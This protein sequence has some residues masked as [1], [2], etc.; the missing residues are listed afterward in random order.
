MIKRVFRPFWSYDIMATEQWLADM[1]SSGLLLQSVNFRQRIFA[2]VVTQPRSIVYRID[3][4]KQQQGIS[5][6]LTNNGWTT[7]DVGRRW[8]IYANQD[9]EVFLFP[10]RD[11]VV[12]KVRS[13]SKLSLIL[14]MFVGFYLLITVGFITFALWGSSETTYVPA[15]YRI[16]DY[17][18]YL[19]MVVNLSFLAWIIYTFSKTK[20]S[21]QKFSAI[22]GYNVDPTLLNI[23]NQRIKK[24]DNL[25]K[26]I[27]VRKMFWIYK[28]DH[29]AEWLETQATRGL[30]LKH[31]HKNN[32][33]FEEG[34]PR[35]T[36]YFF[37]TQQNISEG[38]FDIH[39]QA[40]FDLL[41]DSRLQFGRLIL[42][43]KGY[44]ETQQVP[45]MYT[46][47]VEYLACAKRLLI[48][49]I[50][51]IF[52]WLVLGA[53]QLFIGFSSIFVQKTLQWSWL[54]ISV[55]WLIVIIFYLY[56][57]FLS[58]K[59]YSLAKQKHSGYF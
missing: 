34:R 28:L 29:I 20:K 55:L 17:V 26:L 31:I 59:S 19:L 16:L 52:Y 4:D 43:S 48:N 25:S 32:F 5:Q 2:F 33:Y 18:P 50:K 36:K 58:I 3:F 44:S 24:P 39:S 42:W 14:L 37:D 51:T 1:A 40:G 38:Y 53:L 8:V 27:K 35:Q 47:K 23:P 13:L 7:I 30:L 54:P 15:P 41:F 45:K 11:R 9:S 6:T 56:T 49:N 46:D 57:L 21:L 12:N 10:Q 22:G